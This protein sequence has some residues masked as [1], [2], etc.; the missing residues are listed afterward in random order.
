[1]KT[2]FL[3]LN[4][5]FETVQYRFWVLEF[6]AI[7][8]YSFE[9]DYWNHSHYSQLLFSGLLFAI[10]IGLNYLIFLFIGKLVFAWLNYFFIL[11]Q[12]LSFQSFLIMKWT[13]TSQTHLILV[14]VSAY[15]INSQDYFHFLSFN[16]FAFSNF[17]LSVYIPFKIEYPNY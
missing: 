12:R 5:S 11:I 16:L 9:L 2:V 3:S 17:I 6:T 15:L 1:M 4:A 10:G 13:I 14:W 8:S 7:F